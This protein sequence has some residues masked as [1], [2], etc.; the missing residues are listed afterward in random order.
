MLI[1][2]N[3]SN[4]KFV[5]SKDEI[6]YKDVLNT[7]SRTEEIYILTFNI[8]SKR[9]AL[10]DKLTELNH[11][12]M[13]K[14]ITNIPQRYETYFSSSARNKARENISIYM[15]KLLPAKFDAQI[16]PFFNFNNHAKIIV[17]DT[18]A[19]VGSANFSDESKDNFESGFIIK[20]NSFIKFL[21]DEVFPTLISSSEPYFEDKFIEFK[22]FALNIY[23]RLSNLYTK[24]FT[25]GFY[26]EDDNFTF[27]ETRVGEFSVDTT[28][29][30]SLSI[31]LNEIEEIIDQIDDLFENIEE[32]DERIP[33][34]EQLKQIIYKNNITDILQLIDSYGLIGE[35]CNYDY[36][37]YCERYL[38]AHALLADEE[39]LDYYA[40]K[41]F[42]NACDDFEI[43]AENA[44]DN[45]DTLKD[46]FS[47]LLDN[48]T[49]FIKELNMLSSVN[50]SIDN[51]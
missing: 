47:I 14:I 21:K 45:V 10:I 3:I 28:H 25:W 26:V 8:S 13:V 36:Q 42:D 38:E 31:A 30:E 5:L 16:I 4:A 43:L 15:K 11:D 29:L 23:S 40:Q 35:V 33:Q 49:N 32:D 20:D 48:L 9:D 37:L 6:G 1:Q 22:L 44:K 46:K 34:I 27:Y 41:A 12:V 18:I 51:T 7:F 50:E 2:K 19:Y 24:L 17:T 39:H